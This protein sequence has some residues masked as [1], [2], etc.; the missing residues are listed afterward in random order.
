[1][2]DGLPR[3][4]WSLLLALAVWPCGAYAAERPESAEASARESGEAPPPRVELVLVGDAPGSSALLE[5]TA[6]WF[7]DPR[8]SVERGRAAT[9]E[10]S[11]VFAAAAVPGVRIWIWLR[12]PGVARIFIAARE[13]AA[14]AQSYWVSDVALE[15]GLDE[16]GAE[17]LAQVV[18][19]SALAVYAGNLESQRSEVEARL[20]PPRAPPP[21]PPAPAAKR[22]ESST[23]RRVTLGAEYSLR[24]AGD[25]GFAQVVGAAV[26]LAFRGHDRE[27][28]LHA[29]VGALLPRHVETSE[30]TLSLNG[31]AAALDA[32]AAWRASNRLWLTAAA[33]PGADV[34]HYSAASSSALRTEPGRT[35]IRPFVHAELGLRTEL[36]GV[37]VAV[38]ALISAQ[39][40]LVHYDVADADGR[41]QVLT[42]WQFQPGLMLGAAW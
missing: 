3:M 26:G 22:G 31:G 4:S 34:V 33:G 13:P 42:P 41:R 25:E 19:L 7:R 29:H 10:A 36:G 12:T 15:R 28:G 8:V 38:A 37:T 6:S 35:D 1:M 2:T 5:R 18:H 17:E 9:L 27:L 23:Q 11:A 39:L 21:A 16:L 32:A 24:L 30:L 14:G 40:L 20:A